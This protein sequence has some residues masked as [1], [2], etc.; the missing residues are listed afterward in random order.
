MTVKVQMVMAPERVAIIPISSH[1]K[2]PS[3]QYPVPR[4][5]CKNGGLCEHIMMKSVKAKLTISMLLGVRRNRVLRKRYMTV[6]LPKKLR[7]HRKN[8]KKA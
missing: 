7:I 8:Q 2:A 1:P 3:S 5:V 4:T 6:P